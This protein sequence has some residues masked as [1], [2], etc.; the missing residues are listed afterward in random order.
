MKF[1]A[2]VFDLAHR[3]R[4]SRTTRGPDTSLD[5]ILSVFEEQGYKLTPCQALSVTYLTWYES[6]LSSGVSWRDHLRKL[7]PNA[8]CSLDDEV[9]EQFLAYRGQQ[10]EQQQASLESRRSNDRLLWGSLTAGVT[11]AS[12]VGGFI[13]HRRL[14]L[15]ELANL[16]KQ[17][18][19]RRGSRSAKSRGDRPQDLRASTPDPS[20]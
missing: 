13:I 16:E 5:F 19:R 9:R 18:Q 10:Q 12:M 7:A 14:K 17:R 4:L 6:S 2:P 3:I 11:L 20:A 15:T 8:D 1:D